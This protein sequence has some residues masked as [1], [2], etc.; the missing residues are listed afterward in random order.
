VVNDGC[1][2]L[3]KNMKMKTRI[4]GRYVVWGFTLIELLVVIA[5]I[6]ILA[7]LLLPALA[8]SK[9]SAKV[10]NC[11]S[12][13]RQ[14]GL[15]ANLYAMDDQNWLPAYSIG[16]TGG[17]PTD[18]SLA[19]P[20]GLQPYG[21]IVPMWFCPVR[22]NEFAAAES[23]C[24]KTLGHSLSSITDL[25]DFYGRTYNYFALINHNWWV[26]HING[27]DL[28]PDPTPGRARLPNGWPEKTTDLNANINPILSDIC[29]SSTGGSIETNVN[30]ITNGGHF[31]NNRLESCNT[32]Y[33]DGHTV[34][35]PRTSL[36]W[37]Y[38]GNYTSF[39]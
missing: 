39:Y 32:T 10:T 22:P 28:V 20:P 37:E 1:T 35:V 4:L 36:R 21:L 33:A 29:D 31:F 5:I 34:T 7:A 30:N 27:S 19:M 2:S 6:A 17:N 16:G 23:Y 18:V 26:P 9:F 3:T 25:T 38:Y 11:T 12:N 14:W 8:R 13:Y 15:V 24:L